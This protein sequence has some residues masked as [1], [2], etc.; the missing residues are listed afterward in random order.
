MKK[1]Q[2]TWLMLLTSSLAIGWM[3]KG[4]AAIIQIGGPGVVISQAQPVQVVIVDSNG[5]TYEQT[6]YY[7]SSIGG[8]NIDTRWAGPG[9]SIYIPT[10]GLGYLW[11]NG[12]WVDQEGYYWNGQSRVYISD[13]QWRDHWH[14]YWNDHRHDGWNGGGWGHE[15]WHNKGQGWGNRGEGREERRGSW[16]HEGWHN[17]GEDWRGDRSGRGQDRQSTGAIRRE[18]SQGARAGGNP[19]TRG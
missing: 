19:R 17:R 7:D 1:W 6:A 15:G 12:F 13:P 5:N 14:H 2:K 9:A 3:A 10:L 8:V 4:E 16:G 11:Y 18:G